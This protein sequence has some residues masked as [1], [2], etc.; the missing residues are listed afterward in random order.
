M[1]EHAYKLLKKNESVPM[2]KICFTLCSENQIGYIVETNI[3]EKKM[4]TVFPIL[5]QS[6]SR[7]SENESYTSIILIHSRHSE[8]ICLEGF[9]NNQ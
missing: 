8:M 3:H 5:P 9:P 2:T 1:T 7:K 4:Q 6:K